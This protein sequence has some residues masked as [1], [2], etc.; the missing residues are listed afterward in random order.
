MQDKIYD[1]AVRPEDAI[2]LEQCDLGTVVRL[3]LSDVKGQLFAI[4]FELVEK[5]LKKVVA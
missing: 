3:E 4:K 2:E 5:M 1:V